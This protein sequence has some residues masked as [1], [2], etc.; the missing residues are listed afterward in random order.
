MN[1]NYLYY[2]SI[3]LPNDAWLRRVLLY[4]N[5]IAS[6]VPEKLQG[7]LNGDIDILKGCNEYIPFSPEEFLSNNEDCLT[8]FEN[9][10]TEY[11][12]SEFFSNLLTQKKN[13]EK[14]LVHDSKFTYEL[15]KLFQKKEFFDL[16][17]DSWNQTPKIVGDVYMGLL[18]KH[19]GEHY[20]YIPTTNSVYH[21]NK[22][23]KN[24]RLSMEEIGELKMIDSLPSP[25]VDVPILDI[26]RFKTK[27]EQ[28]LLKF[29]CVL[30]ENIEILSTIDNQEDYSLTA[31]IQPSKKLISGIGGG[32]IVSALSGNLIIGAAIGLGGVVFDISKIAKDYHLKRNNIIA[33]SPY[34]YAFYSK[35]FMKRSLRRK[36]VFLK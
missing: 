10:V 20:S 16:E 25:S 30:R 8:N 32:T 31:L 24:N 5:K 22:T 19:M 34:S 35:K 21:Q 17:L 11:F 2:P 26:I 23:F 29:R 6:I 33:S 1:F 12:N 13:T 28:E 18:A 7:N 4:S 36:N 14:F 15:K 27:R 9:E 3:S